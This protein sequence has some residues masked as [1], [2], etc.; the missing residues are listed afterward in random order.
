MV[1]GGKPK[2]TPS[3]LNEPRLP[4]ENFA[5]VYVVGGEVSERM[6]AHLKRS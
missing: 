4:I 1:A 5:Q 2:S 6:A 3:P